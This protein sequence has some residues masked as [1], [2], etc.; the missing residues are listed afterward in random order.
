MRSELIVR[1]GKIAQQRR[2]R[3]L[4]VDEIL[5]PHGVFHALQLAAADAVA[6]EIDVLVFDAAFL[7]IPLRLFSYRSICSCRRSVCS[8]RFPRKRWRL[9]KKISCTS[10]SLKRCASICSYSSSMLST[11]VM[12]SGSDSMP[13]KSVPRQRFSRASMQRKWSMCAS[14]ASIFRPRPRKPGQRFSPM[15]PSL[16]TMALICASVRLRGWSHTDFAFEWLHSTGRFAMRITSQN[17]FSEAWERSTATPF[18]PAGVHEADAVSSQ[19][20]AGIHCRTA[21]AVILVPAERHH[22]HAAAVAVEQTRDAA[23]EE[24][25]TLDREEHGDHVVLRGGV[26]LRDARAERGE[27]AVFLQLALNGEHDAAERRGAV[28]SPAVPRSP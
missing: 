8:Q 9:W 5:K 3:V 19:A 24:I 7:E 17:V 4:F 26:S 1:A 2:V 6:V 22:A 13:S 25:G 21:Q 12:P 18:F 11:P 15:T 27:I 28:K 16:W 23:P 14:T 20:R 10:A